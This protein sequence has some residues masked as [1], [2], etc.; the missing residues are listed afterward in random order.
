MDSKTRAVYLAD[1]DYFQ[2][3]LDQSPESIYNLPVAAIYAKLQKFDEA[4]SVSAKGLESSP[5][6]PQLQVILAEAM[7]HTGR[8]DEAR[9]I[10]IDIIMLDED[11]YKALKLLGQI[12]K[13]EENRVEAVKYLRAAHL[14]SPEDDELI[15][16]LEE[17]G[18]FLSQNH[19]ETVQDVSETI[20]DDDSE[21]EGEEDE[22]NTIFNVANKLKNAETLMVDIL[23]SL[24]GQKDSEHIAA[25]SFGLEKNATTSSAAEY[26]SIRGPELT[27]FEIISAM[28]DANTFAS[29]KMETVTNTESSPADLFDL[30]S[31][32]S[33]NQQLTVDLVPETTGG[34]PVPAAPEVSAFSDNSTVN[35]DCEGTD[36]FFQASIMEFNTILDDEGKTAANAFQPP[37]P[38]MPE[39]EEG[40]SYTIELPEYND[41]LW[42][43]EF[44]NTM[45]DAFSHTDDIVELAHDDTLFD[46]AGVDENNI[47]FVPEPL[48]P[49]DLAQS[50]YKEAG[51]DADDISDERVT[52]ESVKRAKES[53]DI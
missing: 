7:V 19:S 48:I 16:V 30:L 11:N 47:G 27:D 8:K 26:E 28:V 15:T 21:Y 42:S 24:S 22:Y 52:L 23:H 46:L 3:K 9:E 38:P 36:D 31:G 40:I 10:L 6:H 17:M 44:V 5:G 41:A 43:E 53:G 34:F 50:I 18:E 37:L 12:F 35:S 20:L 1:L 33:Q 49:V 4:L 2:S 25:D 14:K 39:W 13:S 32:I 51:M 45:H 29:D